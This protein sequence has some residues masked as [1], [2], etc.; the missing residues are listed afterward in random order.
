MQSNMWTDFMGSDFFVWILRYVF[1][2][3]KSLKPNV[4]ASFSLIVFA[5]KVS[6]PAQKARCYDGAVILQLLA[7]KGVQY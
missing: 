6:F 1:L 7:R 3:I 4:S 5:A 2:Y